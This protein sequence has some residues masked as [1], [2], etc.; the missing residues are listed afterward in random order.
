MA[1]EV[2][3]RDDGDIQ[4]RT[5]YDEDWRERAKEL[6]GK[7]DPEEKCWVFRSQDYNLSDIEREVKIHFPRG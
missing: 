4:V 6:K 2:E 3:E 5:P 7:W 1:V